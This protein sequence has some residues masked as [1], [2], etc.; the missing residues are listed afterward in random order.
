ME[1]FTECPATCTM[2]LMINLQTPSSPPPLPGGRPTSGHN[3][4]EFIMNEK[5]PRK[6]GLFPPMGSKTAR[7]VVF[8]VGL[9]VL[10]ILGLVVWSLLASSG[11]GDEKLHLQ[12]SQQQ[13]ELIRIANIG[14]EK[15]KTNEVK[16]LATITSQSLTTDLLTL[17]SIQKKQGIK[18]DKK[19]IALGKNKKNDTALSEAEQKNNFDVVLSQILVRDLAAYQKSLRELQSNSNSKTESQVKK[20]VENVNL[21]LAKN[22][23]D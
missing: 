16:N 4:Y 3:P 2:M 11:K 20:L 18:L 21:L 5:S 22:T 14:V 9:I 17:T 10:L 7:I 8:A 19:E 6:T 1:H 12:L 13:T 23:K 15:A